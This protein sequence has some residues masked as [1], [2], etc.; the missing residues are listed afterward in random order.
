MSARERVRYKLIPREHL[1]LMLDP[2]KDF[3]SRI[4]KSH[5]G[6]RYRWLSSHT[7][8]ALTYRLNVLNYG[9][10][11]QMMGD[12]PFNQY[13]EGVGFKTTHPT[14]KEPVYVIAGEGAKEKNAEDEKRPLIVLRRYDPAKFNRW[15]RQGWDQNTNRWYDLPVELQVQNYMKNEARTVKPVYA[16]RLSKKDLG[17]L[18]MLYLLD[19][20]SY[21]PG[22]GGMYMRERWD[23]V[24][25]TSVQDCPV[26][27]LEV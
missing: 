15:N 26:Y 14:T 1:E 9:K 24:Q 2:T 12:F 25:R 20:N 3:T 16:D 22:I 8:H 11:R 23:Y 6:N 27:F 13:V 7:V 10:L 18:S 17:K 4:P 5:K 21:L 19:H